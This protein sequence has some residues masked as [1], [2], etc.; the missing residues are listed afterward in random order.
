MVPAK[1][2]LRN[3]LNGQEEVLRFDVNR[4]RIAGY[5]PDY[6]ASSLNIG[7]FLLSDGSFRLADKLGSEFQFDQSGRLT[8][9]VLSP[10][11]R[12]SYRYGQRRIGWTEFERLPARLESGDAETVLLGALRVP[13][14]MRL[15]ESASGEE[16]VLALDRTQSENTV[17]YVPSAGGG[18]YRR[19]Q[20]MSDGSFL[21][22]RGDGTEVAFDAGGRFRSMTFSTVERMA[23]G[24]HEIAF[25]YAVANSE[26]HITT[27]RVSESGNQKLAFTVFY[28]YD[29]NGRLV[30]SSVEKEPTPKTIAGAG[31][32]P[33]QSKQ[34][35]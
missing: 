12:I 19:L 10:R 13:A 30:G 32:S 34:N 4:Y 21:A 23:Q 29:G 35:R 15:V 9:M 18:R 14:R 5:V 7:V 33:G 6:P 26:Y 27:A 3:F 31:R 8:D 24:H 22:L 28:R 2:V 17:R 20:A 1:V 16:E 25:E 11:Y